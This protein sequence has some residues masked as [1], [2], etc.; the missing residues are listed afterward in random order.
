MTTPAPLGS[1]DLAPLALRPLLPSDGDAAL[2]CHNAVFAA[3]AT[4]KPRRSLAH[5]RWKYLH[6]PTGRLQ[7]MLAVHPVE[8]VVG[9]YAAMPM[10][11]AF[12]GRRSFAAQAVD[13]CVH[14]AWLR[15]GGEAGLFA[16]LGIAFFE[17]W[18]GSASDQAQFVYGLPVAG[19]RSGARHLGWQIARDWDFTFLELTAGMP[20][21]AVPGELAVRRV[22]HFD[23]SCDALFAKLEPGFGVATVRDS[24]YLNWR[25]ADHPDRRYVLYECRERASGVLR[26]VCVSVVGDVL[27]PNTTFLVDWLQPADDDAAMTA[28]LAAVEDQARLDGT[29]LVASVWNPMDPRFLAVQQLGYRVRG[30]QWFLAIASAVYDIVFFREHWYFTLGDSDLL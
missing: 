4:G 19:W 26:G 6:N 29:G 15:H 12:G 11:V 22:Q 25:Y 17:R 21:R 3:P 2:Q 8:G 14:P 9:V 13:H 1:T 30:T 18:L 23:A 28:M 7:Q 20:A 24:R 16:Q 27:R 10:E 5:W